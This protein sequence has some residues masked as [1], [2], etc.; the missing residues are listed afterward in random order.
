M[1]ARNRRMG[2]R[3]AFTLLEVMIVVVIVAILAGAGG[4]VYMTHLETAK[5]DLAKS[6]VMGLTQQVQIYKTQNGDYP[7]DLLT[8]TRPG[9]DGTAAA[10]KE[11][12]LLDPWGRPY[13]YEPTTLHPLTKE[14]RIYSQGPNPG[15]PGSIISNWDGNQ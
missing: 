4:F 2:N 8:L 9:N 11:S 12:A 7:P 3:A 15:L 10:L 6:G 5:K 1:T 13:M 14:P